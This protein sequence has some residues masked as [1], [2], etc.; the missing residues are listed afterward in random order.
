MSQTTLDD[1]ARLLLRLVLGIL[2]FFHGWAKLRSGIGG[3]EAMLAVHGLPAFLAWGVYLG[4]VLAPALL[5]LGVFTR[6]GAALIVV[7]MLFALFLAHTGHFGS[8][9][10]SGGWRLE[11]QGMFLVAALAI[12][13]LGAGRFALGGRWN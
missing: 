9:T 6:L 2:I 1:L 13:M 3:I 11:L 10:S 4:E 12:L 7:N 8:F 5:I